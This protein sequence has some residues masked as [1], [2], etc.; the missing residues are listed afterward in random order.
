M[1]TGED[2][3]RAVTTLVSASES[4]NIRAEDVKTQVTLT[5]TDSHLLPPDPALDGAGV[6]TSA[7]VDTS[8]GVSELGEL[9]PASAGGQ[10]SLDGY[11]V[12]TKPTEQTSV[13]GSLDA[14]QG[15]E[16]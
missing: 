2:N 5:N 16:S 7:V 9:T 11:S 13:P 4:H 14:N 15:H 12:Q 8:A 6:K 10:L 3:H 1:T